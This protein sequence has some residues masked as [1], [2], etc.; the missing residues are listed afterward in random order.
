MAEG[1]G[2]KIKFSV[3]RSKLE[4][5]KHNDGLLK[6]GDKHLNIVKPI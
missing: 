5:I 3:F 4:I 6:N 1:D 2:K